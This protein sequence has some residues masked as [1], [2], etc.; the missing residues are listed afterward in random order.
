MQVNDRRQFWKT[1]VTTMAGTSFLF[2]QSS[3][4]PVGGAQKSSKITASVMAW[5]VKG[6][7]EE[8]LVTIAQS[9]AQSVELVS[10]PLSWSATDVANYKKTAQ[11]LGLK[12]DCLLAQHDWTKRP[13][14]MVN[15]T[16]Q[17]GFLAD[18]KDSIEWAK[19]LE[20][21][22]LIVMS[23][24]V[25]PNMTSDA[26]HVSIVESGARAAEL[27]AAADVTLILE[28]LNSKINHKGYFLTSNAEG[29]AI[30]KTIDNPHFRLLF[31][32]YHEQVQNGNVIR[33]LTEAEPYVN[34]FHVADNPGRN[35]PGT[36]EM[37]YQN[38]YKAIA[39]TGYSGYIAMEYLP[40]GDAA[41]SLKKAILEMRSALNS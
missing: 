38:I 13:V 34:V 8:R 12:F 33:T 22:Q 1:A 35:D 6:K 10:E 37:N 40:L 16:H 9:G 23:G 2:G 28:P 14:T 20:L 27:A 30:V 39:K 3:T 19:K 41:T 5:T 11:S 15:P 17:E 29:L 26:Q 25:Q 21:K 32:I 36:G 4:L 7:F 31:D 18:V 24:N